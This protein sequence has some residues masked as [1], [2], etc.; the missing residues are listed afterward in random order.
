M[1]LLTGIDPGTYSIKVLQ[2]QMSGPLFK[3]TRAIEVPVEADGD[4]EV[5]IL[6][7]IQASLPAQKLKP[8]VNRLGITGRDLMIRYTNV[9]PV[10]LWRLKMLMDFE[11]QDMASSSGDPLASDY[12]ILTNETED[13]DETVLVGLVKSHFLE[14]R[15]R[16]LTGSGIGFQSASPNCVALFN[17]YLAFGERVDDEFTFLLDIGDKN[18]E[19]AVQK[20][21]ELIFA[22][23]LAGGG[24]LFTQAI[25]DSWSVSTEKAREL[26]HEYGNVTPR[27]RASYSSSSEEKVANAI[28]GVAGQL[29]GMVQSTINFARAQSGHRDMQIGRVLLSGGGASLPGLEEYLAGNLKTQVEVFRPDAGI[30]FSALPADER[31]L[32]EADPAA[33]VIPL[34][35]ARMSDDAEAF[36]LDL[37]PEKIKSKRAFT[38]RTL[39]MILAGVAA[40]CFLG[41]LWWDLGQKASD[42]AAK[43]KQAKSAERRVTRIRKNYEDRVQAAELVRDKIS[44]IAE[45]SKSGP[46]LLRGLKLVQSNAPESVWISYV[47]TSSRSVSPPGQEGNRNAQIEKS[48]VRVRGRIRQL[49]SRVTTTFNKYI[50]DVRNDAAKPVVVMV[51]RPDES[52][53]DFEFTIDFEGWPAMADAD[54]GD[55]DGGEAR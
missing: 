22:R 36:G 13:G 51:R 49:G 28:M 34:G 35:L 41:F 53:G 29:A 38:Q 50:E 27:G 5:S 19:M 52:G 37:I 17:A 11:I 44:R 6:Q 18:L 42:S 30:D 39:F 7:E 4:V 10:P 46:Y 48:I 40:A 54:L 3:L 43:L 15:I 12:N 9:P 31:E 2:G 14:S 47:E 8:G 21:G 25:A 1:A 32:F 33:F 45:E 20:D 23:N 55:E 24:D 26:K 16:A